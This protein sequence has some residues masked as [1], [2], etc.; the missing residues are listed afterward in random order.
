MHLRYLG[1]MRTTI[2]LPPPVL[3]QAKQLAAQRGTSLSAVVVDALSAHLQVLR[4]PPA[5]KPFELIVR[6]RA[7]ARFP[8]P[9]EIE[10]VEDEEDSALLPVPRRRGH[11]PP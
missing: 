4:Q 5:D 3:A 10:A 11:A 9:N 1:G 7:G 8:T 6:G 2:D